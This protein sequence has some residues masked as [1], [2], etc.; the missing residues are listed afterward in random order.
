MAKRIIQTG[1]Q[2]N[3]TVVSGTTAPVIKGAV[4]TTFDRN[5]PDISSYKLYV[6][7]QQFPY[8]VTGYVQA[9]L[10][11]TS[12]SSVK[13]PFLITLDDLK[14]YIDGV[15]TYFT[16]V[17]AW[18]NN[19]ATIRFESPTGVGS[20]T[21]TFTSDYPVD[22]TT[23][24]FNFTLAGAPTTS[25]LIATPWTPADSRDVT[26]VKIAV[27][28]DINI[29]NTNIS[30]NSI[31]NT[32]S[33]IYN[34]IQVYPLAAPDTK[35]TV[36]PAWFSFAIEAYHPDF[37]TVTC[38][39]SFSDASDTTLWSIPVRL[40][41]AVNNIV[42][43]TLPYSNWDDDY[44][45]FKVLCED[46]GWQDGTFTLTWTH[47]NG[48][49]IPVSLMD[50]AVSVADPTKQ[51]IIFTDQ[52]SVAVDPIL[53]V[54]WVSGTTYLTFW[55][56]RSIQLMAYL[57]NT[58]LPFS[59][60]GTIYSITPNDSYSISVVSTP[61]HAQKV[62]W[63]PEVSASGYCLPGETLPGINFYINDESGETITFTPASHI[64][65]ASLV[66][67]TFGGRISLPSIT[68]IPLTV[69]SLSNN[70]YGVVGELP[71]TPTWL[72][73]QISIDS[74]ATFTTP[75]W[76][77]GVPAM[78]MTGSLALLG[79]SFLSTPLTS[80]VSLQPYLLGSLA[81]T[82]SSSGNFL[83]PVNLYH[84]IF[85]SD[86]F[87]NTSTRE[88][89]N[90]GTIIQGDNTICSVI[91]HVASNTLKFN[92]TGGYNKSMFFNYPASIACKSTC[93]ILLLENGVISNP[94][95]IYDN[96]LWKNIIGFSE[97]PTYGSAVYSSDTYANYTIATTQI[98]INTKVGQVSVT[99]T[100]YA[101][102][103]VVSPLVLAKL[104][105]PTVGSI[106]FVAFD[107]TNKA[108][109]DLLD[110]VKNYES[111]YFLKP[112]V[113]GSP[114]LGGGLTF[115]VELVIASIDGLVNPLPAWIA[116]TLVMPIYMVQFTEDSNWADYSS[117]D[118]IP[119][120]VTG[121]SVTLANTAIQISTRHQ[122]QAK[123][124]TTP[125][126]PLTV[127]GSTISASLPVI[128]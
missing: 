108:Y 69:V 17:T 89:Y 120:L 82:T 118:G 100:N 90:A 95:S 57:S 84:G 123:F 102:D 21:G 104:S 11:L 48:D 23:A 63:H 94:Y 81:D 45:F 68:P 96:G 110:P 50:L 72:G 37:S 70:L 7:C 79:P 66:S 60:G 56:D 92:P 112:L 67:Y 30:T 20:H 128:G 33:N 19:A 46:I 71:T 26:I 74:V 47:L 127:V 35:A 83:N 86:S 103:P 39:L 97:Y 126:Y 31:K 78:L 64:V 53:P 8:V 16:Y 87:V 24:S 119:F 1:Y 77:V 75:L 80:S 88:Y 114:K 25:A 41:S 5:T 107:P 62:G 14:L 15:Q 13:L 2:F 85:A 36:A 10:M 111:S 3:T 113:S 61:N 91:P 18:S 49:S 115:Q 121:G 106:A 122:A 51:P 76:P 4:S 12:N 117:L 9:T 29:N 124:L 22:L 34:G 58:P 38:D 59:N 54:V 40:P 52:H 28:S 27:E 65:T 125:F 116:P 44:T 6:F 109:K 105:D 32:S 43:M 98:P 101:G 99:A 73:I 93:P 42:N 55:S